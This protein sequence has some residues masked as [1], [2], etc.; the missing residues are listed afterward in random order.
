MIQDPAE[1]RR[2]VRTIVKMPV[3]L[4][5]R[6]PESRFCYQ[7]AV[8]VDLSERGARVQDV[9]DLTPEQSLDL[10]ARGLDHIPSRVVWTGKTGPGAPSQAGLEFLKPTRLVHHAGR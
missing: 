2:S 5:V 8:M 10:I 7:E 6:D 3:T 1:R 9:D 4:R